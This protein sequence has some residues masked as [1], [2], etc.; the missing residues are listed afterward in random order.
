MQRALISISYKARD[1]RVQFLQVWPS[2][3]ILV[4]GRPVRKC[5]GSEAETRGTTASQSRLTSQWDCLFHTVDHKGWHIAAPNFFISQDFAS[6]IPSSY[7]QH[8]CGTKLHAGARSL[9]KDLVEASGLACF[10]HC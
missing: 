6:V 9:R 5:R 8:D 1:W 10:K 7:Y 4:T 2:I 3:C